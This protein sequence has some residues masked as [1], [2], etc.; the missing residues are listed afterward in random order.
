MQGIETQ[1]PTTEVQPCPASREHIEVTPGV[2]GGKPR[3][4]GHRIKVQHVA[5][6]HERIGLSPDEIVSQ[7][8]GLT[9]AD[10][11]AALAYYWDHREQIEADKELAAK[12]RNSAPSIFDRARQGNASASAH[13]PGSASSSWSSRTS[14]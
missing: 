3:I 2:C 10:V 11:Y 6:W 7:H 9:L 12:L 5:I 8:P 13:A 4:K 1:T 14:M